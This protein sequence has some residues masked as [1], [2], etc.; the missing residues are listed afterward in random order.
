M[1]NV[2]TCPDCGAPEVRTLVDGKLKINLEPTTGKC[3]ATLGAPVPKSRGSSRPG[4]SGSTSSRQSTRGRGVP[5]RSQSRSDR[6]STVPLPS[7]R[8]TGASELGSNVPSC[9]RWSS[10][11]A[12]F[13]AAGDPK[14]G[15][16]SRATQGRS[17]RPGVMGSE[18]EPQR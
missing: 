7:R 17:I 12:R 15:I 6:S 4:A 13:A 10:A 14:Y 1:T 16:S 9:M 11:I 8:A 5:D 2:R 18:V 3:V